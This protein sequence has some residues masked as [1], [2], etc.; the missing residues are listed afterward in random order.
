[1]TKTEIIAACKAQM[2]ALG[3]ELNHLELP[4]LE[5]IAHR[6]TELTAFAKS[7]RPKPTP[8][9]LRIKN[10]LSAAR[11]AFV[12]LSAQLPLSQSPDG[13]LSG[14]IP[15]DLVVTAVEIVLSINRMTTKP[16]LS[17][18]RALSK[19]ALGFS[20]VGVAE[21]IAT[22]G[23]EAGARTWALRLESDFMR[24]AQ[25]IAA[26]VDVIEAEHTGVSVD[27]FQGARPARE[28]E[29]AFQLEMAQRAQWAGAN[30]Y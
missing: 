22:R 19:L 18:M 14:M 1:M 6:L 9:A 23:S 25:L 30:R 8:A 11:P 4:G 29:A 28:R 5:T 13:M 2:L 3:D 12:E 27:A 10:L 15:K 20:S 17:G 16:T 26:A 7:L 24:S 21:R